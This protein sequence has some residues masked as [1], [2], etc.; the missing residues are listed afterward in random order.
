MLVTRVQRAFA[1]RRFFCPNRSEFVDPEPV[2]GRLIVALGP[3]GASAWREP[4]DGDYAF[5]TYVRIE[6]PKAP[7]LYLGISRVAPVFSAVDDIRIYTS[8]WDDHVQ[9]YAPGDPLAIDL[10]ATPYRALLDQ[11]RATVSDLGWYYVDWRSAEL[12][13]PV[14]VV[15]RSDTR[16]RDCLFNYDGQ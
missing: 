2:V 1:T 12:D 15:D 4:F 5:A 6:P 11:T 3:T 9:R 10:D 8:K 7:E 16:L 14:D 13:V